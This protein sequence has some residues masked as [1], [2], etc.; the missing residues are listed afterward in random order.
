MTDPTQT[1]DDA[2]TDG[3]PT[4]ATLEHHWTVVLAEFWR[5]TDWDDLGSGNWTETF[6]ERLVKARR[7]ADVHQALDALALGLNLPGIDLPTAD[8]DVLVAHSD[9]AMRVLRREHIYLV[10]KANETVDAF[11]DHSHNDEIHDEHH[12]DP[13]TS[14]LSD[15]VSLPEGQA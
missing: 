12:G 6:E 2:T 4:D 15:Y 8:V 5:R 14:P 13:T 10:N 9:R 7:E 11:Y 3:E 1:S